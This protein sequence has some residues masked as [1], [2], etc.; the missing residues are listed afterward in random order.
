MAGLPF[1]KEH[2]VHHESNVQNEKNKAFPPFKG[3]AYASKHNEQNGNQ[4]KE[5]DIYESCCLV[6][7][8]PAYDRRQA[9][10][11]QHI[12]NVAA[13]DIAYDYVPVSGNTGY[14]GYGKLRRACT[15]SH[16]SG[17]YYERRDLQLLRNAG[18]TI[19]KKVCS[20]YEQHKSD[21]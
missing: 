9:Q 5:R 8:K 15:E 2:I 12:N 21:Y 7:R 16:N 11:E 14:N 6:H 18:G 19:H 3:P 1:G 4:Y 10:Y 13:K 20:F 17:T